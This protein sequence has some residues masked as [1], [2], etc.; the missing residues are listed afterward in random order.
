MP[1]I[2]LDHPFRVQVSDLIR[3]PGARRHISLS[4]S[5]LIE[6]DQLDECGPVGADLRIEELGG[7]ILVRGDV[8]A[9]MWLR[10][11]RCLGLVSFDATA[12]IVQVYGEEAGEDILP[13]D[14]DGVI[15]LFAVLHDEL[16]LSVPLVPLCSGACRGL[17]PTCGSD[18]NVDPCEGHSEARGSPFAALGAWLETSPGLD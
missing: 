10:C 12:P 7:G 4:G 3:R 5:M 11:N 15:D 13:I 2:V 8:K 1:D 17:C 14:P 16:C 18:L 9:P 6:L